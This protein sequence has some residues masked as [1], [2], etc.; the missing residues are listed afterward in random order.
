ME[1][2]SKALII[3]GAIL[4]SILII[5]FGILIYN[6]AKSTADKSSDLSEVQVQAFNSAFA[7]YEGTSVRGSQV[8]ALVQAIVASNGKEDNQQSNAY[9]KI[10][11]LVQLTPQDNPG[12]DKTKRESWTNVKSLS[13]IS[14]TKSYKVEFG[15]G[16]DG[17]INEAKISNAST[18]TP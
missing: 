10:S 7:D 3:A 9:V 4:L 1:N 11:G 8:R 14:N 18:T 2:A 15:Y 12:D 13:S 5:S 16:A 6:R 17:R